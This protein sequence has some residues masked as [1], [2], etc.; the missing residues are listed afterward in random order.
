MRSTLHLLIPKKCSIITF[1]DMR[2]DNRI[3]NNVDVSNNRSPEN[4]Q[5]DKGKSNQNRYYHGNGNGR[6]KT[7]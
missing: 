1:V 4:F 7:K 2:Q 6:D 5:K 3:P